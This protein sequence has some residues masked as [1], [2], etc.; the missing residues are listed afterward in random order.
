MDKD[1]IPKLSK[2]VAQ[3]AIYLLDSMDKPYNICEISKERIRRAG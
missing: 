2:K 3:N 1:Y